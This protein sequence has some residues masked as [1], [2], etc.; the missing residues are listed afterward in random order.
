LSISFKICKSVIVLDNS[1]SN[2]LRETAKW[3]LAK[4]KHELL[5][6]VFWILVLFLLFSIMIIKML[7][8]CEQNNNNMQ[9]DKIPKM[10][11]EKLMF[12]VSFVLA[13]WH[14]LLGSRVHCTSAPRVP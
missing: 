6:L 7:I 11:D 1:K 12:R 3:L 5:L 14:Y 13:M 8:F 4:I 10:M 9:Q 2:I